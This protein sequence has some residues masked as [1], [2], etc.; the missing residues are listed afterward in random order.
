MSASGRSPPFYGRRPSERIFKSVSRNIRSNSTRGKDGAPVPGL[1][2]APFNPASRSREPTRR[3]PSRSTAGNDLL[4]RNH[5]YVDVALGHWGGRGN[6][7]PRGCVP[8]R[9]GGAEIGYERCRTASARPSTEAPEG[10]RLQEPRCALRERWQARRRRAH[11]RGHCVERGQRVTPL[12]R[13]AVACDSASWPA[14]R[15]L[16]DRPRQSRSGHRRS[17][18]ALLRLRRPRGPSSDRR[19]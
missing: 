18:G 3:G 11:R 19:G 15:W 14:S 5:G 6:R 7:C 2:V 9:P 17:D 13:F 1:K 4:V 12:A 16:R 10:R 8:G